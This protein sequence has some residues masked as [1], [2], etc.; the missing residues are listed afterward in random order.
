MVFHSLYFIF[1]LGFER[2]LI[3]YSYLGLVVIFVPI[4]GWIGAQYGHEL[5]QYTS[6]F[7]GCFRISDAFQ[8]NR[9]FICSSSSFHEGVLFWI[10]DT[11]SWNFLWNCKLFSQYI[12]KI[13]MKCVKCFSVARNCNEWYFGIVTFLTLLLWGICDEETL[14]TM[15]KR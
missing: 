9:I 13:A 10:I 15:E 11:D 7:T 4:A 3:L 1:T 6:N 2:V 12:P 5:D 8:H 14:Q